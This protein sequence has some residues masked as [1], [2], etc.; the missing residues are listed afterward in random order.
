MISL[1]LNGQAFSNFT[2]V[3]VSNSL[4][5]ISGKFTFTATDD[6]QG[7]FPFSAGDK[8]QVLI[9]EIVLP[10]EP[11]SLVGVAN[12]FI[13]R[14]AIN[15]TKNNHTLRI[16]GRDKTEDIIDSQIKGLELGNVPF[17]LTN[18]I[19]AVFKFLGITD[20]K[21]LNFAG[22]IDPFQ[23]N[24]KASVTAG[25]SGFAFINNYAEQRQVLVSND[26]DGN[27]IL[28]RVEN[29][30]RNGLI[31]NLE[32]NDPLNNVKSAHVVYDHSERF[33]EYTVISQTNIAAAC[34]NLL[35][36]DSGHCKVA[37]V[38]KIANQTG[39]ADIDEQIR[40]TRKFIIIPAN[41]LSPDIAAKRARWE[42][43]LRIAR[44]RKYHVTVQGFLSS[45][46]LI[47]QTGQLVKVRDQFASIDAEL[48]VSE[49]KYDF[50]LNEGSTTT[51]TLVQQDVYKAL[52][53]RN[54]LKA[55]VNKMGTAD[56]NVDLLANQD[57]T[58]S[59]DT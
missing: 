37:D 33:H 54:A 3:S 6:N 52:L 53:E 7:T 8:V 26:G 49:I 51:L 38:P 12:G 48:I 1:R 42:R 11:E 36:K 16:S 17:S 40:S 28:T 9:S 13:D 34:V 39:N 19:E 15:Y 31:L 59:N 56:S 14:I 43:A 2:S 32:N 44:S 4:Q 46:G 45:D 24:E 25:E 18:V 5:S 21:I 23:A 57:G 35:G 20:I 47:W 55:K 30:L 22:K 29:P 41:S 50:T 27:I 58:T 10:G